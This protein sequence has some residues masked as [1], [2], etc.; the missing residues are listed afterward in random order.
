[1]YLKEEESVIF[2]GGSAYVPIFLVCSS[3]VW[4][5]EHA[6]DHSAMTAERAIVSH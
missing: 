2:L 1:M 4:T 3:S 6:S 5:T